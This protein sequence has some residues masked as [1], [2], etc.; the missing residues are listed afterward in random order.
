MSN[1]NKET[2][3]DIITVARGVFDELRKHGYNVVSVERMADII[4]RVEE[5][6]KR[7]R[8]AGAAVAQICGEI[9][10]MVGRESACKHSVTNCNRLG[11][12][13]KMREALE[14]IAEYAKAAACHTED[15]HLLGYLNQ[16]E[17]W[18]EAA[19]SAPP[20]NC[21]VGTPEE[22]HRRFKKWCGK[23]GIDGDMDVACAYPDMC[24]TLCAL[25]WAQMP[26]E[27]ENEEIKK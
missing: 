26:Y 21:D 8:E 11:N 9:G 27:G 3:A 1:V 13:A 22:Q 6:H 15:A 12:A 5:A 19:L 25:R 14:N 7:E 10:E 16:I 4:D 17:R 23:H 2:I 24:C 20:R 18:V